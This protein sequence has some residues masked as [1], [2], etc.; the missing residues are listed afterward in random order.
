V[1]QAVYRERPSRPLHY[2]AGYSREFLT[3]ERL[4]WAGIVLALLP[5]HSIA[6]VFFK[7]MIPMIRPFCWDEEFAAWDRAVHFGSD[8]WHY[9]QVDWPLVTWVIDAAYLTV[10]GIMGALLSWYIFCEPACKRRK[11]FLWTYLLTWFLLGNVAATLLSSSGPCY[12]RHV[13]DGSDPFE[14]LLADL[15]AVHETHALQAVYLQELLWTEYL[16]EGMSFGRGISAMPSLHVAIAALLVIGTWHLNRV[17]SLVLLG[18]AVLILIGS[19]H[20]GW[21]YAIDGYVAALGVWLIWLVCG[22]MAGVGRE[23]TGEGRPLSTGG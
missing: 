6:F 13:V 16:Q 8:P 14:P 9:L 19:V 12:Y 7:A 10:F 17:L 4:V 20:L 2:L 1:V 3:L 21:H 18:N 23:E 15:A 22:W 11:Q 5:L